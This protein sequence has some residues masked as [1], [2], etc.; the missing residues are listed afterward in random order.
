MTKIARIGA[1]MGA[2]RAERY[3]RNPDDALRLLDAA[4]RK[5]ERKGRGPLGAVWDGF[6]TLCRLTRAY[7]TRRYTRVPWTTLL[8]AFGAVV[9]F[10]SPFDLIPDFILGIGFVDDVAVI[11][12]V[13]SAIKKELQEFRD[14]ETETRGHTDSEGS[15]HA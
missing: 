5:A 14:W 13:L 12:W 10:A 2:H 6:Q 15:E 11:G 9:Y 3:L 4:G 1:D 8:R 7:L